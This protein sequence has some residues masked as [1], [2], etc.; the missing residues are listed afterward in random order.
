MCSANM[1]YSAKH[2]EAQS[3]LKFEALSQLLHYDLG[4]V[5]LQLGNLALEFVYEGAHA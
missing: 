4:R 1:V 2:D 5:S 3:L